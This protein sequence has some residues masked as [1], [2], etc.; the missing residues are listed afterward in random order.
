MQQIIHSTEDPGLG[1]KR[2]VKSS[3]DPQISCLLI[4]FHGL[5]TSDT[6]YIILVMTKKDMKEV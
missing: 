5:H 1:S 4:C 3:P 2:E 6:L